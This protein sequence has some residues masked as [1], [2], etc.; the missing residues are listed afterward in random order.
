[1]PRVLVVGAGPAGASVAFLLARRGVEV[2][3]LE[4][5]RDF[6]REFRGEVL[7]PSGVDALRQ[8]GLG[9]VIGTRSAVADATAGTE[10]A[11]SIV[12]PTRSARAAR[13][14]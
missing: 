13:S 6:A 2:T 8:M 9:P 3:L 1:M 14:V 4:R 5:Q 12:R 7:L 10:C 11:A